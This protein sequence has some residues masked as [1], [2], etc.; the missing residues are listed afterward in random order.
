M[1]KPENVSCGARARAPQ[2]NAG[3]IEAAIRRHVDHRA[4]TLI[5]EASVRYGLGSARGEYR[6]DFVMVTRAGYAT[7][8]EVKISLADWRKDLSKPKWVGMPAWIT[9]F[10]YVVPER[11]GIP[12]WVPERAGVWHVRPQP[13]RYASWEGPTRPDDFEIVVARAPHVLGREKLPAAVLGTWHKNLYYRY[14]EQRMDAQ[15]RIAR[16]VR[17]GVA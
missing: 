12:E 9:R 1:A 5:P 4:N 8:L 16:H 11:L 2:F 3:L 17:E 6:A 13:P 10:V 7:E 15:R 14:W